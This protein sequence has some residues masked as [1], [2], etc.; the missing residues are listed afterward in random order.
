MKFYVGTIAMISRRYSRFHRYIGTIVDANYD[1][2]EFQVKFVFIKT[3]G[4]V[5]IYK[6]EIFEWF[7]YKE[8]RDSGIRFSD[9]KMD[10]M[11]KAM[12]A[13]VAVQMRKELRKIKGKKV[14]RFS[15][16]LNGY[17]QAFE[18]GFFRMK[19]VEFICDYM[20]YKELD[21]KVEAI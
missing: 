1:K 11:T 21:Y 20:N 8:L 14:V 4:N 13:G 6:D 5:Q 15:L 18:R 12:Y 2:M 19:D 9:A 16:G 17:L 7:E 10:E 3:K